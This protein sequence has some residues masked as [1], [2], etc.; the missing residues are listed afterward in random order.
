MNKIG[1]VF[2]LMELMFSLA[3][4]REWRETINT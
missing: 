1:K 2:V 3:G 4:G